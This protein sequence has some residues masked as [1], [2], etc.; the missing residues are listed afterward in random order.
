MEDPLLK[1]RMGLLW[2]EQQQQQPVRKVSVCFL[3]RL[4]PRT[5]G[6]T[7]MYLSIAVF[8]CY[9]G[10][11]SCITFRHICHCN[12]S[13][14]V[15][16]LLPHHSFHLHFP[17]H[18][19]SSSPF[20][21]ATRSVFTYAIW[22]LPCVIRVH[23]IWTCRFPLFP[24]LFALL[25]LFSTTKLIGIYNGRCLCFLGGCCFAL[26]TFWQILVVVQIWS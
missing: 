2:K 16:I 13:A 12:A 15:E 9:T 1:L 11:S 22:Y 7:T 3:Y 21:L 4:N 20:L 5:F 6:E 10:Y 25:P 17:F 23:T 24:K 26:F 19:G 18:F 8:Q 14:I